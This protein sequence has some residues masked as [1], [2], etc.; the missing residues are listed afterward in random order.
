MILD[1]E[2]LGLRVHILSRY[3]LDSGKDM[4]YTNVFIRQSEAYTGKIKARVTKKDLFDAI[5]TISPAQASQS[6]LH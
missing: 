2:A 6:V 1:P 3:Q 5:A 4:E